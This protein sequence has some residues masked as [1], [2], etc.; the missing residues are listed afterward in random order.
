MVSEVPNA[1]HQSTFQ[2][3]DTQDQTYQDTVVNNLRFKISQVPRDKQLHKLNA[4]NEQR[5]HQ[6]SSI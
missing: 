1:F 2:V 4:F 6:T 5:K 3:T